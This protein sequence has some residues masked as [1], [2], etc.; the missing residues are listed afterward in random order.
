MDLL[1][2][3]RAIKSRRL[4]LSEPG[5]EVAQFVWACLLEFHGVCGISVGGDRLC[6]YRDLELILRVRIGEEGALVLS[7]YREGRTYALVTTDREIFKQTLAE[8]MSYHV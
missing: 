2:Q 1:G 6:L 7:I 5:D 3:A 8:G 4:K